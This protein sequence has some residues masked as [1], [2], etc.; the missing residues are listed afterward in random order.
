ME[1]AER[2]PGYS[3][4]T[5][6]ALSQLDHEQI[7]YELLVALLVWLRGVEGPRPSSRPRS[8]PRE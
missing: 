5:L 8:R 6:L 7:N 3:E 2:Y 4:G 1:L